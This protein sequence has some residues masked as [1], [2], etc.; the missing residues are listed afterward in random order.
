MEIFLL[1]SQCGFYGLNLDGWGRE[2]NVKTDKLGQRLST[3]ENDGFQEDDLSE[4]V[5]CV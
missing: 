5:F 3:C 1:S 2:M 4:T